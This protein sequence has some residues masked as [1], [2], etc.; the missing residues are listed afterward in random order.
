MIY[1]MYQTVSFP[2]FNQS[3]KSQSPIAVIRMRESGG[4]EVV[5]FRKSN[6]DGKFKS[7]VMVFAVTDTYRYCSC[8]LFEDAL[9][10]QIAASK[11]NGFLTIVLPCHQHTNLQKKGKIQCV[12][13]WFLILHPELTKTLNPHSFVNSSLIHLFLCTYSAPSGFRKFFYP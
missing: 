5:R 4:W 13:L 10:S 3:F 1:L 6:Q 12:S 2:P 11:A 9:G 7:T 8:L